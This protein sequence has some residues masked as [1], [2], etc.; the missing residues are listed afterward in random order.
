MRGEDLESG[1]LEWFKKK[2]VQKVLHFDY[3]FTVFDC[4]EAQQ[5]FTKLANDALSDLNNDKKF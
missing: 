4:I 2:S 1:D 3:L 5:F